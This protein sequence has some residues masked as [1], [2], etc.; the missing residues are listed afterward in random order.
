MADLHVRDFIV[1]FQPSIDFL[2]EFEES[3]G[4]ISRCLNDAN[5]FTNDGSLVVPCSSGVVAWSVHIE[6]ILQSYV[7][8]MVHVLSSA[9]KQ[10]IERPRR[11][12]VLV[13][14]TKYAST[15]S[16]FRRLHLVFCELE[17]CYIV[18]IHW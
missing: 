16:R 2:V 15:S 11:S 17:S 4:R 9:A 18:R 12:H 5:D 14:L 6:K 13:N 3:T 10:D 1:N 7:A 8:W